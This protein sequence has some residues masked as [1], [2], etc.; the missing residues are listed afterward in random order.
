[1]LSDFW[2]SI[3]ACCGL[4]QVRRTLFI[5]TCLTKLKDFQ[6]F[7]YHCTI[8]KLPQQKGYRDCDCRNTYHIVILEKAAGVETDT[9]QRID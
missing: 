1:M 6:Y 8:N 9:L 4:F 5:L 7:K 2:K 3:S